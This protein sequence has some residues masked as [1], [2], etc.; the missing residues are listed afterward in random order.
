MYKIQHFFK[1][2]G[3][4]SFIYNLVKIINSSGGK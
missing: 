1:L 2:T 4:L 3:G